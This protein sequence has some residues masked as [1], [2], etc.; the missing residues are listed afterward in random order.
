[1]VGQL[2]AVCSGGATILPTS[3]GWTIFVVGLVVGFAFACL[4]LRPFCQRAS[5]SDK[6][7]VLT[8]EKACQSQVTFPG[9]GAPAPRWRFRPLPEA[10]HG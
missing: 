3:V 2:S 6:K 5:P 4:C 1:M 7:A 10:A 8:Y 9:N